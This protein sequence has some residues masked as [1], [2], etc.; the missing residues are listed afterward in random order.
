M[1]RNLLITLQLFGQR[2]RLDYLQRHMILSGQLQ[3]IDQDGL[4]HVARSGL[5]EWR[6]AVSIANEGMRL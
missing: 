1:K 4:N 6:L 3:Q 2:A 5:K